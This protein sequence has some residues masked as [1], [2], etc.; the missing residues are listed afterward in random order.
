MLIS[1]IVTYLCG[2][3]YGNE[4]IITIFGRIGTIIYLNIRTQIDKKPVLLMI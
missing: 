1:G 3:Y 2:V 4:A